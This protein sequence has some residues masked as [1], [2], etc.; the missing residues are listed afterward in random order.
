M[1]IEKLSVILKVFCELFWDRFKVAGYGLVWFHSCF[2]AWKIYGWFQWEWGHTVSQNGQ[3]WV[4]VF[5]DWLLLLLW[6]SRSSSAFVIWEHPQWWHQAADCCASLLVSEL[7]LLGSSFDSRG[8][9]KN[10]FSNKSTKR[11]FSSKTKT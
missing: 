6:Q 2:D 4:M 5:Q 1:C 10:S 7:L 11:A 8:Q 9:M 3:V